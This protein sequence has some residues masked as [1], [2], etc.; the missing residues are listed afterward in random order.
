MEH[1]LRV[2]IHLPNQALG[3]ARAFAATLAHL[4]GRS[5]P[6]LSVTGYSRV[7][8][9]NGYWWSDRQCWVRDTITLI[10]LDCPQP[11]DTPRDA[12]DR[13]IAALKVFAADRY[14]EQGYDQEEIWI[15]AHPVDH[16]SR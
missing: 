4:Q 10:I 15:V 12:L 2:I 9:V 16:Y 11:D 14:K 13:E 8:R 1:R 6:P 5:S 3:E 7:D